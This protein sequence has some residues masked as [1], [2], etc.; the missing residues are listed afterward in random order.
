MDVEDVEYWKKEALRN[1]IDLE[2]YIESSKELEVAL[3]QEL[4]EAQDKNEQL[5]NECSSLKA[6]L[7]G[8]SAKESGLDQ[9]VAQLQEHKQKLEAEI[10]SCKNRIRTLEHKNSELESSLRIHQTSLEDAQSKA[11]HALEQLIVVQGEKEEVEQKAEVDRERTRAKMVELQ[12]DL[13]KKEKQLES[14]SLNASALESSGAKHL[15]EIKLL[16]EDK[17]KMSEELGQ[18]NKLMLEK[19]EQFRSLE[20]KLEASAEMESKITALEEE[21]EL[22]KVRRTTLLC[23]SVK[24]A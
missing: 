4:L 14:N 15:E 18:L 22:S 12:A 6:R 5:L 8:V 24:V 16:T 10:V 11:D 3:E 23:P 1:R 21:L 2:E 20:A 9:V 7:E 17:S 19:E 13:H